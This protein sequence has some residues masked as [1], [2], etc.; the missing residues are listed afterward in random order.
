MKV[1]HIFAALTVAFVTAAPVYAADGV[2]EP[3]QPAD[4]KSEKTKTEK[5][6]PV[7]TTKPVQKPEIN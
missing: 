6:T 7:E 4:S 1:R 3:A 5:T 2:T